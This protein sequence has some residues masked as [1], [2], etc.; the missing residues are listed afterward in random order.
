MVV[1]TWTDG[2]LW[3]LSKISGLLD[4]PNPND[5]PGNTPKGRDIS[6]KNIVLSIDQIVLPDFILYV[7]AYKVKKIL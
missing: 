7:S 4:N 2:S 5:R 6:T 1:I 3:V